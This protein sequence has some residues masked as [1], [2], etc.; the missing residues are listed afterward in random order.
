MIQTQGLS[1]RYDQGRLALNHI[2]FTVNAGEVYCLLGPNGAGKTTL[3]NAFLGLVPAAT[4]KAIINGSDCAH[5][6][7]P[8]QK[9]LAFLSEKPS[10]YEYLSCRGNIE[11]LTRLSG[12]R[13]PSRN[14]LIAA[15]R[16]VSLPDRILESRAKDLSPGWKQK[17]LLAV[18]VVRKVPALLLDDPTGL[19]DA[20]SAREL[21]QEL[22]KFKARGTAVLLATDDP[23]AG[24]DLADRIGIL[25][26]GLLTREMDP[27]AMSDQELFSALRS[28]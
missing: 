27:H 23:I 2:S 25:D 8:A 12:G 14:D 24:R 13:M 16:E 6:A 21:I 11:L 7:T 15:I 18:A 22:R 10:L 3:L 19:L 9:N 26:R 1:V 17:L 20:V 5:T 28:Y 4:G